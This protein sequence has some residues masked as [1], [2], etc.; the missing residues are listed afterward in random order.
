MSFKKQKIY[1]ISLII[2]SLIAVLAVAGC[3]NTGVTAPTGSKVISTSPANEAVDV[4]AN[5]DITATF[6]EAMENATIDADSFT[7]ADGTAM[8]SGTIS[9]DELTATASFT[10][11]A[12]LAGG[13]AYTATVTTAVTDVAGDA[14]ELDYVWTF[15]TA[16]AGT[17]GTPDTSAPTV[18]STIAADGATDV[19]INSNITATFSE[20]MDPATIAAANFTLA[21]GV[22]PV[23]GTVLYDVGSK[24]A[25]LA[26]DANLDADT[27]Y[28]ATVTTAA[29][30]VAGNAIE[31]DKVWTFTTASAGAG[32]APVRLGTAGNF[33]VLSKAGISTVPASAITGNIGVS[34]AAETYLTG[35]S[36]TK[37]TGYSTSDQVTGFLYAA[38]MTPPTPDNMTTAISDMELAYT[39]AADRTTPDETDFGD[40]AGEIGGETLA[41]GLYKWTTAVT[42]STDVTI[43]GGN[44]NDVWIFQIPDNLT[45][46][47]GVRVTLSGDA[48][49]RNIFWQVAGAVT[50]GTTAH[51]EGILLCSTAITFGTGASM[52]GRALAQTDVALDQ[53]T[54]V[55]PAQ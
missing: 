3:D 17:S 55:E 34:P 7:L 22:G 16:A 2:V 32:P 43:S 14:L 36:Q 5:A 41:P 49:A 51:V 12:N 13:T 23:S 6:S 24:T 20:A 18:T 28:T 40:G 10:T 30:D 48:Q 38:D 37:A 33:A 4:A 26:P 1:W 21:D 54:I 9:Y 31:A 15:T 27:T 19:A 29:T 35:F 25:V 39:D 50:V 42:I 53:T 46:S 52:N 11:A 8:V 44:A 47:N 45:V